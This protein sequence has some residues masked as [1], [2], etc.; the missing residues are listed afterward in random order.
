MSIKY[1]A[2]DLDG[3][4]FYPRGYRHCISKRNIK[5][6][7]K[8]IDSGNKVILVTS[9]SHEYT[10]RLEKEIDRPVDVINCTSTQIYVDNKLIRDEKMNN[11]DLEEILSFIETKCHPKAILMTSKKYPCFIKNVRV[12]WFFLLMYKIYWI[13]QFCYR[14]HYNMGNKQFMEELREGDIYK[15]L[16]F[17]GLM[18]NKSKISEEI[19]DKINKQFPHITSS[20]TDIVNEITPPNCNK[21]AGLTYYCDYLHIDK[22]DVYVVG[23]SGNDFTMFDNFY[24]NSYCMA[25]SYPSVKKR[26]KHVIS[27]VYKL[28]KFVL[29][30]E[31]NK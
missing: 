23:D 2:T 30:G 28:E 31:E 21:G 15:L 26:A 22:K 4:L 24:E 19:N 13:F 7:R 20:W 10:N 5:F 14:E 6:L 8:W 25:H 29:K 12:N 1:L 3:T 16:I 18:K 11:K 9:R 27:R 17:F